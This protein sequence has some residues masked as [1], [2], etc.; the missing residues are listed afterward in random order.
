MRARWVLIVVLALVVGVDAV[1]LVL[2][3]TPV[4]AALLLAWSVML[5]IHLLE[6]RR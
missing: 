1:R 2:E 6:A 4:A 3:P 5:A